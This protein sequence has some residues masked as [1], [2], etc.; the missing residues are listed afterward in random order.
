MILQAFDIVTAF[1]PLRYWDMKLVIEKM[2]PRQLEGRGR[3]FKH[4][5]MHSSASQY[6]INP[7]LINYFE[8]PVSGGSYLFSKNGGHDLIQYRALL[9]QIDE[10]IVSKSFYSENDTVLLEYDNGIGLTMK[11][12]SHWTK[13]EQIC[14]TQIWSLERYNK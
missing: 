5:Q 2:I 10:K 6:F 7:A 4:V 12:C 11:L 13:E 1:W 3:K 9:D 8:L 14:S